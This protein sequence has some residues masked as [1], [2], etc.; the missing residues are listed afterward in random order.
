MNRK[1]P[2][3]EKTAREIDNKVHRH[4][5]DIEE[6]KLKEKKGKIIYIDGIWHFIDMTASP[7]RDSDR[8][9]DKFRS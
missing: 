8:G 7:I 4:L 9:D 5:T 6:Q 1:I 2:V 3:P